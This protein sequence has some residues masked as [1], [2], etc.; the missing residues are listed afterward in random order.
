MRLGEISLEV[1][2]NLRQTM[3]VVQ[4]LIDAHVVRACT[5][6]ECSKHP[7]MHEGYSFI[8]VDPG[9]IPEGDLE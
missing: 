6:E 8:L 9:T 1:K 2:L 3:E 4:N 5:A 7:Y